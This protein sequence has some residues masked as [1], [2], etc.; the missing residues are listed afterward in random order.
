M[1]RLSISEMLSRIIH[2]SPKTNYLLR[3]INSRLGH[4]ECYLEP[5]FRKSSPILWEKFAMIDENVQEI[6]ENLNLP[7]FTAIF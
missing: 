6:Q 1:H 2:L 4:Y 3:N 5:P 7:S